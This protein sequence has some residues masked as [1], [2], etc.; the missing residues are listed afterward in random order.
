MWHI[1]LGI[2]AEGGRALRRIENTQPAA[3]A[4]AQIEQSSAKLEPFDN[5]INGRRYLWNLGFD[6]RGDL[7]IFVIDDL[8]EF[9]GRKAVDVL[10]GGVSLLCDEVL[11]HRLTK[12]NRGSPA[13]PGPDPG[14]KCG[15]EVLDVD[16]T[17]D[18]PRG[19]GFEEIR[20]PCTC[21]VTGIQ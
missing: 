15:A 17:P 19:G 10:G 11:E 16:E 1:T 8:E 14:R 4:G 3:G 18:Q 7:L 21:Q 9:S 13:H 5:P 6:R 20:S 2:N 12:Y